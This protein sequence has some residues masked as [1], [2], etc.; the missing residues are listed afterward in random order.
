MRDDSRSREAGGCLQLKWVILTFLLYCSLFS[1]FIV[2]RNALVK[3]ANVSVIIRHSINFWLPLSHTS[4]L[5]PWL[6]SWLHGG[7][8]LALPLPR[9][10]PQSDLE[11]AESLRTKLQKLS[12]FAD[13]RRGQLAEVSG[14][15]RE[16]EQRTREVTDVAAAAGER[17]NTTK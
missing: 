8:T 3:L 1:L 16:Q 5:V 9:L 7:L 17:T 4:S 14:R 2:C 10:R 6:G 12:E 13:A 15:A 11:V